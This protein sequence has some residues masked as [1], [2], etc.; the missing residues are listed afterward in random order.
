MLF[1]TK[2]TCYLIC[3]ITLFFIFPIYLHIIDTDT[4]ILPMLLV[5]SNAFYL[6]YNDN[7]IFPPYLRKR[8]DN[9]SND[10][11]SDDDRSKA[12]LKK[13]EIQSLH[14]KMKGI[15]VI[16]NTSIGKV[17]RSWINEEGL[18]MV[19]LEKDVKPFGPENNLWTSLQKSEYPPVDL[20]SWLTGKL[21]N[22]INL[23]RSPNSD[24]DLSS[25]SSNSSD[26]EN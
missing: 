11:P 7:N 4:I 19:E 13:T 24:T 5:I 21:D 18:W 20:S 3:W 25:D 26:A 9:P 23:K 22:P 2:R 1:K 17:V 6:Q 16:I 12:E 15:P 14:E 8:Q 10:D